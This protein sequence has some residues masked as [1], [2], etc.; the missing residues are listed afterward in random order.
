MNRSYPLFT[1]AILVILFY[2]LSFVF[3]RIGLLSKINHRKFWNGLLL[4]AFLTTGLIGLVMAVKINYKLEISFYDQLVGYHVGFGI[5]MA[6]V[7]FFH[8]W[9]H[10][11]YYLH[12][13]KNGKNNE[14]RQ[15]L[16]AKNDL[17]E[18]HLKISAFLLGSTSI[19][20][21]IILLREFLTI[22]NGNELVIALV[23]ANWMVLTGLGGFLGK[24]PLRIH[25]A[26]MIIVP[27]LLLLSVLPFVTTLL[28]NFLK[29]IV[30]PI[31]AMI[32]LFQIFFAS[33]LLL[34]PFCLVSGFLFTFI[35]NCYSRTRNQNETGRIYGFE[36][37][38]SIVGGMLSGLLFIFVF[39]SVESL[40][41]M[42]LLNGLFLFIINIKSTVRKLVWLPVVVV[43]PAFALLFIHPEKKIRSW[44]YPNQE[45]EVS[46]D[47]PQGNIVITR[48]EN[49]WS[50]YINN[51]LLFDSE[52]FMMNE[53]AV[54][55]TML[56][57]PHPSNV[58]LVSA[59][60]SG[61]MS[62]LK[63]YKPGSID[64]VEDN[65]WLLALM[66]DTL[67]KMMDRNIRVYATD[68]LRFIRNATKP[69]DVA[70]LN[71]PGPSTL[72][73]NRFYTLEFFDLLKKKLSRDGVISFGL[74]APANY[75][76]DEAVDLNSTIYVT[77]KKVFQNVIIIPGEKNYFLASDAPLSYNIAKAVREK[78][79][80]NRYVN[81][82]YIDDALLK[83]R[84]ET[85]LSA[86]NPGTEINQNLKPVLYKLQ[87][88]Y[89]LSYFKGNYRIIAFLAAILALFV[90]SRGSPPS[91][92]MF[93]TGFSASGLEILLLFGLQVFFGNIYLLTSFVFTAFMVGLAVGS[94]FGKS[95]KHDTA[96][97]Y[98]PITQLLI[99]VFTT[100]SIVFLFSDEMYELV[101]AIVY[102][103]YLAAT[104]LIGG[105][106][107]FQFTLVSLIQ[108][109][110]YA[111]ISGKTYSYDLFG[112]A[113]GALAVALYLVPKIGIILSVLT[114]GVVNLVFGIW[115]I[116]KR[117]REV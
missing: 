59:G 74:Q 9:W 31:G 12:L 34:I 39:S 6:I 20:A 13:F 73:T 112:S 3:S 107:G 67:G 29:N 38:G 48:R 113:L 102:S 76:N 99:G 57:H 114:I 65:Q 63:K 7:G 98:I 33:L 105:L 87:L 27:G 5:G 46:K 70:I 2:G 94:F 19:I 32:S 10:L 60:L 103:L 100:G 106:T 80:E 35:A 69:Y 71:L 40:L 85:I 108:T 109:G 66:K 78:G 51:L 77:L 117:K 17:D 15:A 47:S 49:M 92:V 97:K 25:K 53:E 72:Q 84:G 4:I 61:Q 1:I 95:L 23:L 55:F 37:A 22:F 91:R 110:S 83:S 75:M 82:F 8:F 68:P 81:Q 41:V 93:L 21:Q 116:L 88:A 16:L 62:E 89:W 96:K 79:I 30:F 24:Y 101:P 42:A 54:H 50:V 86:L 64:Y 14:P 18:R 45:I 90:F 44:V 115:L 104:F 58:L 56:Q 36:S 26:S 11:T 43:I 28:I 52:N 111:E